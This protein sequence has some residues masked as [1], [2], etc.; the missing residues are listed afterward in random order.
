[1]RSEVESV[2]WYAQ[3]DMD[4][5]W[6]AYNIFFGFHERYSPDVSAQANQTTNIIKT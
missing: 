4:H 6:R 3:D 1:M 5:F 2:L